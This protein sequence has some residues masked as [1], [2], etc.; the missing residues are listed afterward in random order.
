MLRKKKSL[1]QK[2]PK[3][4]QMHKPYGLLKRIWLWIVFWVNAKPWQ[5]IHSPYIYKLVEKI[6]KTPLDR[7]K[8]RS[9]EN[10]RRS[11]R[12]DDSTVTFSDLGQNGLKRERKISD[13]A[14]TSA[15]NRVLCFILAEIIDYVKPEVAIELGTSLGISYAYQAITSPETTFYTLE[16]SKEIAELASQNL[17]SLGLFANIKIG[18]FDNTLPSVLEDLKTIDYAFVDGNHQY[19]PTVNYFEQLV[20]H[21]TPN[22]CIIF[23]DIY[24]SNGMQQAWK[25]IIKDKRVTLS[26]D[27]YH[28]GLVF[29]RPGVVKQH[30]N[31]RL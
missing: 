26:V 19:E 23:D 21:L 30:F 7:S 14:K 11:L 10:L 17:N 29:I 12:G 28:F 5:T 9:V 2:V 20:S 16:G 4:N 27:C 8:F 22:G 3:T 6:N 25:E 1:S 31:V 13:I 15:K 24:W 18:H